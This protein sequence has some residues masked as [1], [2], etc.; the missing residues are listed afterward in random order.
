MSLF[1]LSPAVTVKEWD[2]SQN[3]PTLPSARTGAVL[4]ADTGPALKIVSITNEND[5]VNT[6]G[7]P[8]A[9]NFQDW[10]QCWNFLQ[11]A[12]S[13][14]VA[15]P[16]NST[17][18]QKN[19]VMTFDGTAAA[20]GT[21][22]AMYN[23]DQAEA[24]LPTIAN[25]QKLTFINRFVTTDQKLAI[26]ITSSASGFGT[27]IGNEFKATVVS[28]PASATVTTAV[29][30]NNTLQV[31]SKLTFGP[32]S[33]TQLVT[34]TNSSATAIEFDTAVASADVAGGTLLTGVNLLN[35]VYDDGLIVKTQVTLTTGER[36]YKES[37]PTFSRLTEFAPD[38]AK[39]EFLVVLLEKNTDGKYA[40]KEAR[41]VSYLSGSKDSN[42]RNN[43]AE[44]AFFNNSTS[45]FCKV[46]AS[47]IP[48]EIPVVKFVD[49]VPAYVAGEYTVGDIQVAQ[50]L[51]ADPESFDVNILMSHPLDINGM[52]QIAE[53]RK[54]C[55]AVVAPMDADQITYMATNG[56]S[57]VTTYLLQKYGTQQAGVKT[58]STFGT[59]SAMYANAKYQ[60]D[61]FNDVNRWIAVVG[62]VAGL[63]AATD[64]SRDT[65]WAPAGGER[66]KIKNVIKLAFNPNKQNRDDLYV[67]ALNPIITIQ[68]EG[69]GVVYGQKTSTSTAS[70]IDRV[71]VRRLLVY[72]EKSIATAARAGLFEFN[73]A[74]TR[75]RLFGQIDP[76]LR[77]V[78]SRR[79]LYDYLL[80]CDETN[81]TAEVIDQNG[82]IIDVYVKPTKV[83]EFISLNVVVVKTGVSFNEVVG[84]FGG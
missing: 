17:G 61:K 5:L 7:K 32:A 18:P 9:S 76:F 74:F 3:T 51:F 75:S 15:R 21:E 36:F 80:V 82:L 22:L 46:A 12:S 78:K 58:F 14:Y 57:T 79:G 55:I 72:L 43:F 29:V 4:R 59:Y 71:N 24:I 42:G 68:G 64:S 40:F 54:D 19:A 65:W 30:N 25:A 73:D 20:S 38:W 49:Y 56:N 62:D 10:F 67:N 13:L 52:A 48:A 70:A 28:I 47:G 37:L 33:A 39:S 23:I 77:M 44:D 8:N 83:A 53:T 50:D 81:N 41:I 34:I 11:Y 63:Y 27:V 84:R 31:G 26:A 6:F 45:V 69:N 2:L 1:S 35:T 66:G 16:L 60:Y